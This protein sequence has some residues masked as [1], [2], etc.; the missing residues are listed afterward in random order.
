MVSLW[1]SLTSASSRRL[2]PA[3]GAPPPAGGSSASARRRPGTAGW[4][5][6]PAARRDDDALWRE[7]FDLVER[8][9]QQDDGLVAEP[10]VDG[11]AGEVGDRVEPELDVFPVPE[12]PPWPCSPHEQ[13]GTQGV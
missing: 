13:D 8:R 12:F 6:F 1:R 3:G 9:G 5:P 10:A 11:A 2:A 7:P 4:A